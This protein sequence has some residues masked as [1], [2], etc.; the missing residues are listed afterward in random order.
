MKFGRNILEDWFQDEL[1]REKVKL[2]GHSGELADCKT[3]WGLVE[4]RGLGSIRKIFQNTEKNG[5]LS[6]WTDS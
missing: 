1:S 3:S 5:Y 6:S 2:S 4:S